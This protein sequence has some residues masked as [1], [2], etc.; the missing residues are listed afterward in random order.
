MSKEI[1]N[2]PLALAISA[3][4]ATSLVGV[5]TANAD[6]SPFSATQLPGGYMVAG[7][8]EGSC[9]GDKEGEGSCG[10]KEGEGSCGDKKAEGSC[11]EG[12]CGADKEAE[13]SCGEDKKAEGSCGADKEGAAAVEK[14]TESAE[15]GGGSTGFVT[16]L[17]L[18]SAIGLRRRSKRS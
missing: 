9:G 12:S 11:G 2:K 6:T 14:A 1:K 7:T 4:L 16:L 17:G 10:D 3:A 13:G 15:T 18:L 8:G 5:P